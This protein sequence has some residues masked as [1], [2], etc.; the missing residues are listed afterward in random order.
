M[1]QLDVPYDLT[2]SCYRDDDPAYGTCDA[3]VFRKSHA[4]RSRISR[5]VAGRL[6]TVCLL[7]GIEDS[8]IR[9]IE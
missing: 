4:T 1:Q 6:F 3:C 5:M 7:I 2:Q 8:R 9:V